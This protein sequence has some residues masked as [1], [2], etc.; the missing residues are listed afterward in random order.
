M[1]DTLKQRLKRFVDDERAVSPVVGFVL[2]FALI[3]IVFT[4][5]QSSVVPAQN[6]EVEFKH[7]QVV[8][9]QMTVLSDAIQQASVG[10]VQQSVT[11]STGLQYPD[12]ALAINPGAPA[13]TLQT[14][15]ERTFKLDGI[16]VDGSAYWDGKMESS[17]SFT[18]KSVAYTIG[19][20]VQQQDPT[21]AI[22]NGLLSKKYGD[23]EFFSTEEH[24]KMIAS[25]KQINM[26]LIGGEYQETAATASPTVKPISTSTEYLRFKSD[27]Q[28][29][30]P[31]ASSS[32]G[33][34]C[35][36]KWKGILGPGFSDENGNKYGFIKCNG[37]V[38][39]IK[40]KPNKQFSIRI[41]KVGFGGVDQSEPFEV[42]PTET[43]SVTI[44]GNVPT[45]EL[46][47]VVGEQTSFTVVVR[48][49]YGNP[50][51]TDVRAETS[52]SSVESNLQETEL[53]TNEDGEATFTYTPG[54]EGTK[55][56]DITLDGTSTNYDT[57]TH[58]F[59]VTDTS[60]DSNGGDGFSPGPP[61]INTVDGSP[62]GPNAVG[63]LSF[64]IRPNSPVEIEGVAIE[65]KY[66]LSTVNQT[67]DDHTFGIDNVDLTY[68]P[69][70]PIQLDG[71]KYEFGSSVTLP[72]NDQANVHLDRFT[73]TDN[74]P[75]FEVTGFVDSPR[76]ADLEVIFFLTDGPQRAVYLDGEVT[77]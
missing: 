9:G 7:S 27:G 58:E 4:L 66:D 15:N 62:S 51:Q 35:K 61:Q 74:Q 24:S 32:P 10:G 63:P 52:D 25:G 42:V 31:L 64:D 37:A 65:T 69:S 48:D 60:G 1:M 67:G 29:E 77:S 43:S 14:R 17:H 45:A 8:E 75:Q 44:N 16:N 22:D 57:A 46:G 39:K 71:R 49:R 28:S 38:P 2:I 53:T 13:G 54:S 41:T 76:E 50:I 6:E 56:I 20:N 47:A 55:T 26:Y 18:T 34:N 11:V 23:G 3:M 30:I 36:E 19:Y 33:G 72:A 5:Y 68:S 40:L 70:G 21:F 12:R 59:D 73:G